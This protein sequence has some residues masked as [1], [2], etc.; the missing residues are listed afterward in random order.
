[1]SVDALNTAIDAL[2]G[3]TVQLR[4]I[5]SLPVITSANLDKYVRMDLPDSFWNFTTLTPDQ[6]TALYK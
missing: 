4:T 3:K 6:I 2:D 5:I 1:M